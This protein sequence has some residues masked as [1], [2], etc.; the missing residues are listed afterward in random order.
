MT[1]EVPGRGHQPERRARRRSRR[2]RSCV[3]GALTS[4][5]VA[6]LLVTLGAAVSLTGCSSDQRVVIVRAEHGTNGGTWPAE[7]QKTL[8]L[9]ARDC[10]AW[11]LVPGGLGPRD[12]WEVHV[13][14]AASRV[15]EAKIRLKSLPDVGPATVAN[16]GFLREPSTAGQPQLCS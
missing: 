12:F 14:I 11:S 13:R 10:R 3:S 6:L 4:G 1:A 2:Y 5:R 8:R 16:N 15:A 9:T 7:I